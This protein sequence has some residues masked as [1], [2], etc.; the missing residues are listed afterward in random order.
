MTNAADSSS[1]SHMKQEKRFCTSVGV[2]QSAKHAV[3]GRGR[4]AVVAARYHALC[5]QCPHPPGHEL[6][7]RVAV[8]EL[9]A[10]PVP[11]SHRRACPQQQGQQRHGYPR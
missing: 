3:R 6:V 8:P 2:I 10:A 9:A 7:L 5:R 11:R 4:Q 1:S